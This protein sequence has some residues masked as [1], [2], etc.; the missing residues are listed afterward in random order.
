MDYLIIF[1][2]PFCFGIIVGLI[3]KGN[4][5]K[6]ILGSGIVGLLSMAAAMDFYQD[7][8]F[9]EVIQSMEAIIARIIWSLIF[10]IPA[11]M[12]SLLGSLIVSFHKL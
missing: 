8:A 2:I 1:L 12:V 7:L 11:F 4:A 3:S 10:F 6:L 9:R 5:L